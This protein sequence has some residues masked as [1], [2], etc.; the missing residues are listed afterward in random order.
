MTTRAKPTPTQVLQALVPELHPEL[1]APPADVAERLLLLLH[2]S[3]DWD[4]WI[5]ED[6][7]RV[8]YWDEIL[9]GR[10][11]RAAYRAN[12]LSHWWSDVSTR[13]E[14]KAPQQPDRQRELAILLSDPDMQIPVLACL[15]DE[16]PALILRVRIIAAEAAKQRETRGPRRPR[17]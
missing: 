13:L 10:V 9:P 11:Q 1:S 2:Y 8:K 17:K 12:N 15:R 14:A 6:R 5:G 3:I 7:S 4:S 16:L